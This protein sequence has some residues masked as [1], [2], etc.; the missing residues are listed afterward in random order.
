MGGTEDYFLSAWGLKSGVNT[1]F[2]GT[3]YF[4]QWGIVGSHTSAF[5]WHLTESYRF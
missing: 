2:F 5:R 3:V 1:P 4:D